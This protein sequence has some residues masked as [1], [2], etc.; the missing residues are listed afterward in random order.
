MHTRISPENPY[1]YGRHGFAW[2]HVPAGAELV[3]IRRTV[4]LPFGAGG[5]SSA[6]LLDVLEHVHEQRALLG[7]ICRVVVPGGVVIVTVPRQHLFSF[8]DVGNFK[9]LFPRLHRW[10]DCRRHSREEYHQRH[11]A[12]PDGLIGDISARKR[13]HEHFTPARLERL[14]RASGLSVVRFD[15]A[16]L[17]RRPIE[18]LGC[19]VGR[20]AGARRVLAR[21]AEWDDRR[22]EWANL[23]CLARKKEE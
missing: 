21:L 4:P 16:G 3:H 23:F 14:L 13:W 20:F 12:D 1:G 17:L 19:L 7:E 10:H 8:L 15:G 18:V 6:S 22:Y 11:V 5:F 2:E 9:F